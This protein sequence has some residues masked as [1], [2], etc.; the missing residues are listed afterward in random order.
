[1]GISET[2]FCV[3]QGEGEET[4][5]KLYTIH[6]SRTQRSAWVPFFGDGALACIF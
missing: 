1:M 6:G 3:R 5:W 4:N 2:N